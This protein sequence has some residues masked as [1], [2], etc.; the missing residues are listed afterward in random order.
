METFLNLILKY[1]F[2]IS[3]FFS[4]WCY[5]LNS[6]HSPAAELSGKK[7]RNRRARMSEEEMILMQE[8]K[9]EAEEEDIADLEEYNGMMNEVQN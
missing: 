1:S 2:L 7:K 8:A 9:I 3:I 6:K 4:G 5:N